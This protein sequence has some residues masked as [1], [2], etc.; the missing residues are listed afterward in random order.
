VRGG[1]HD[2]HWFLFCLRHSVLR[3]ADRVYDSNCNCSNAE[4]LPSWGAACCAPTDT[5][6]RSVRDRREF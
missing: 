1:L 2:A 3:M 6:V 4:R 5:L